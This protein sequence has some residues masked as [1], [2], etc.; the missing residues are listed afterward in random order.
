LKNTVIELVLII[1]IVTG[2]LVWAAWEVRQ[3]KNRGTDFLAL[4]LSIRKHPIR[5]LIISVFLAWFF[6]ALFS[7]DWIGS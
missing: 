5:V 6:W 2:L 3:A 1:G 4:W 7:G